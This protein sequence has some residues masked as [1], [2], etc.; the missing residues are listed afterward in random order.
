MRI[1]IIDCGTNTFNLLVADTTKDSW[2]AVFENK[3]PV[4]L[5]AGGFEKRQ[6]LPARF[7]RGLDAIYCHGHNLD[8]YQVY[9]VFA[10][11]TSAI[12]E[13][14]NGQEFV[15]L[16]KEKF[17]IEIKLI[18]GNEEA[19]LIYK[20]IRQTLDLGDAPSLI[21]DIGG[22]STEFI[23]A[24]ST[25][26]FWKKS[27]LLG[28]SRLYDMVKPS[29][30]INH[31]EI[32]ELRSILDNEL[33]EL[34]MKLEEFPCPRLIGSSGSF[35]TMFALYRHYA[36]SDETTRSPS[37]SNDIPL[38]SFPVIHS[39]LMG[40]TFEERLKHPSIPAIR[41]E[42]MPLASYLIKY[43]LE[44]SSIKSF[45]HSA[46]SLKEGAVQTL[47]GTLELREPK[48]EEEKPEDYLDE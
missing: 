37:P 44:I 18:D 39:W 27:F 4:K 42:Y 21:M 23:I 19:E 6:I 10:F 11:A 1:A 40:S 5:G 17:G 26:I 43:V 36:P 34:K 22:G 28:V 45:V 16:V 32:Q 14:S 24:N 35:D 47:I 7:I 41:A 15:N 3:I 31:S 12:R 25:T 33:G 46:Y 8:N 30:R 2:S 48:F 9:K 29:D 20:G 13:A 38:S